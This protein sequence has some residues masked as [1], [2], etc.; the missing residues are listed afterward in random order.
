[1]SE[2]NHV[3]DKDGDVATNKV[4]QAI[5][6][7][8]SEKRD[9]ILRDFEAFKGYLGKRIE[10]AENLGLNEEQLAVI[11]ERVAGYLAS[12]EDPRNREEMLLQELWKVGDKE[13]QH[14]L[15]HMLVRLA[16]SAH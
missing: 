2:H 3:I 1:M 10:L 13:Q 4:D 5:S 16:Q 9:Q 7:M 12:H 15:A 11:A 8:D 14:M 6:N